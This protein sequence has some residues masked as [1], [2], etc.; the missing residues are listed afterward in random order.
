MKVAMMTVG[1]TLALSAV[2][3]G[4][5]SS[6]NYLSGLIDLEALLLCRLIIQA[7]DAGHAPYLRL[8]PKFAG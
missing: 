3:L 4:R 1:S 7:D 6:R 5:R 8:D 2:L